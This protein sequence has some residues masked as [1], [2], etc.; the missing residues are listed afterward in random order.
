MLKILC[1][2]KGDLK[3]NV[4]AK[5]NEVNKKGNERERER[6]WQ[7]CKTFIGTFARLVHKYALYYSVA[8]IA[9]LRTDP[10]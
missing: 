5:T 7:V 10:T 8:L 1:M 9:V 6:W 4:C 2:L 3:R